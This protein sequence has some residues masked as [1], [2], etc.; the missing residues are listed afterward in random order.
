M[1]PPEVNSAHRLA[2]SRLGERIPVLVDGNMA[3]GEQARRPVGIIR[4]LFLR[5]DGS[6]GEMDWD[7][8]DLEGNIRKL[9]QG[10]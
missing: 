3:T 9:E 7:H 5:L 2:W 10:Q 4:I 6:V 8:A 1:F